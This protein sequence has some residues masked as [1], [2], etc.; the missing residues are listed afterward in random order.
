MADK[1]F[2]AVEDKALEAAAETPVSPEADEGRAAP[3]AEPPSEASAGKAY[4]AKMAEILAR[5]DAKNQED[6]LVEEGV[7]SGDEPD[8]VEKKTEADETKGDEPGGEDEPEGNDDK[9]GEEAGQQQ[10][11]ETEEQKARREVLE[12]FDPNLIQVAKEL[13]GWKTE[14]VE[15]F[16]ASNPV[17]ARIT[18]ANMAAGYNNLSLQYAQAARNGASA[19]AQQAQQN[20]ATTTPQKS[21]LDELLANPAKFKALSEIAG[22]ELTEGFIKPMLEERRQMVE[23][24]Q[25]IA[26]LRREALVRE[27]TSSIEDLAK[28]GFKDFYGDTGAT[29]QDQHNNR[30]KVAQ[31]ADQIRAGAGIQG[32]N[33]SVNEALKRAH[34]IVTADQVKAQA[35]KE[36]TEQVRTRA[37]QITSRPTNRKTVTAAS[38]ATKG[39]DAAIAAV[40]QWMSDK[41]M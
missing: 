41:G 23:D 15:D 28:G 31:V 8:G 30:F 35:R 27:V 36:I 38:G 3:V 24:R 11:Q 37:T 25:F 40:E 7:V 21:V 16:I 6:E 13:G 33:M 20:G 17:L 39:D 4:S 29:T 32:I 1:D 34:L 12:K 22:Q 26:G 10:T 5:N 9:G 14:D 18:F 2:T 19:P